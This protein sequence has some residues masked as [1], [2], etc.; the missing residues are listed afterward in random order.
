MKH[1]NQLE[2]FTIFYPL[3]TEGG[4]EIKSKQGQSVMSTID[5]LLTE[6]GKS[7]YYSCQTRTM[8]LKELTSSAHDHPAHQL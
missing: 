6:E 1:R 5:I 8:S 2:Q 3:A 4:L 7:V